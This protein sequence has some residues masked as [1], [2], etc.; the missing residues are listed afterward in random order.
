L[1]EKTFTDKLDDPTFTDADVAP[2]IAR[3]RAGYAKVLSMLTNERHRKNMS[4]MF[5]SK[6]ERHAGAAKVERARLPKA[7]PHDGF[8]VDD[9][10]AVEEVE[11]SE[12][13][14]PFE[15]FAKLDIGNEPTD[16]DM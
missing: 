8:S 15:G 7:R 6:S 3:E 5:P 11:V 10:L 9:N 12:S 4:T 16:D 14:K 13:V 2:L 1:L